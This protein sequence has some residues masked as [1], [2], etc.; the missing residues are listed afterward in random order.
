MPHKGFS[1]SDLAVPDVD[2]IIPDGREGFADMLHLKGMEHIPGSFPEEIAAVRKDD[3]FVQFPEFFY[4]GRPAGHPADLG[5]ASAGLDVP[6]PVAGVEDD[7]IRQVGGCPG[8]RDGGEYHQN[9]QQ[10]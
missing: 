2:G 5:A 9:R 4:F 8:T 6:A 7:Q 1:G 10:T 3:V